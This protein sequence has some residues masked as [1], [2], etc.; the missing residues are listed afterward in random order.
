MK[1]GQRGEIKEKY[2][3]CNSRTTNGYMESFGEIGMGVEKEN[4]G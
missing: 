2:F 3:G 1:S 4:E